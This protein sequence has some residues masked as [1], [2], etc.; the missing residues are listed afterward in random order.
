MELAHTTLQQEKLDKVVSQLNLDQET[1]SLVQELCS[2]YSK[3]A[4]SC[5]SDY[6]IFCSVLTAW[7]CKGIQEKTQGSTGLFITRIISCLNSI[8]KEKLMIEEYIKELTQFALKVPLPQ[9]ISGELKGVSDKFAFSYTFFLKY[10]TLFQQLEF[11]SSQINED[12]DY[13]NKLESMGWLIYINAR[14]SFA[15]NLG[16]VEAIFL[17]MGTLTQMVLNAPDYISVAYFEKAKKAGE[18]IEKNEETA[19]DAILELYPLLKENKDDLRKYITIMENFFKKAIQDQSLTCENEEDFRE[20]FNPKLIDSNLSSL[21]QYYQQT[22]QKEDIDERYYLYS[23]RRPNTNMNFTPFSKQG[24]ANKHHINTFP[25]SKDHKPLSYEMSQRITMESNLADIKCSSK[26]MP[27]SPFPG[28]L[29][30]A[31]TP[32]TKALEMYH[33]LNEKVK[34]KKIEAGFPLALDRCLSIFGDNCKQ[35][36][37]A[38]LEEILNLEGNP[39][40]HIMQINAQV[41]KHLNEKKSQIMNLYL[42]VLEKVLEKEEKRGKTFQITDIIRNDEFHRALIACSIETVFF[43]NNFTDISF[44]ELLE[45]CKVQAFEFWKIIA[46][47]VK[48]DPKLPQPILK[49]FYNLEVKII[50]NLAW[51]KGSVI[52][53]IITRSFKNQETKIKEENQEKDLQNLNSN[54][55]MAIEQ[56]SDIL[57]KKEQ[58][59]VNE[60]PQPGRSRTYSKDQIDTEKDAQKFEL[61]HSQELFFKRLLHHTAQQISYLCQLL[62]LEEVLAERVWTT[63]KHIISSKTFLLIGRHLSQMILCCVYGVCKVSAKPIKFSEI[64]TKYQELPLFDKDDF[65]EVVHNVFVEENKHSDIIR[66]YNNVFIIPMKSFLLSLSQENPSVE[67]KNSM[68]PLAA[69]LVPQSVMQSPLKNYLSAQKAMTPSAL[70]IGLT[71]RTKSLCAFGESP[72]GVLDSINKAIGRRPV[73]FKDT[74]KVV[75]AEIGNVLRKYSQDSVSV[76]DRILEV[77]EDKD[78]KEPPVQKAL[79][80]RR[81]LFGLNPNAAKKI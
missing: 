31:E 23:C 12:E 68:T 29:T 72:F 6:N 45:L 65:K 27:A 41:K 38:R 10:R 40:V 33:W 57:P 43:I 67:V 39:Q 71:P 80:S 1:R 17:L 16:L 64:I 30:Q 4:N 46:S 56:C 36:I 74:P 48:F 44:T 11:K 70:K 21:E 51:K 78:L 37:L 35:R 55:N 24:S 13:I 25:N 18:N 54:S 28:C 50:M 20:I 15:K 52:Q 3:I 76:L 63:M 2:Q 58:Q 7:K 47:F 26:S 32:M 14:N 8:S 61:T 73:D 49:H 5:H 19:Q 69:S 75:L 60:F 22:L 79:P 34:L 53:Q 81:N 59:E 42:T 9:E 62:E 77:E 66:F